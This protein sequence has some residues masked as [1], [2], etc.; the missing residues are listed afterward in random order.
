MGG[1]ISFYI[2]M[3][4]RVNIQILKISVTRKYVDYKLFP[5]EVRVYKLCKLI[6]RLVRVT[7]YN[8]H[9]LYI[10]HVRISG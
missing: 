5:H 9:G 8:E 4:V 7:L 1:Y 2:S 6:N 10:Y 3:G